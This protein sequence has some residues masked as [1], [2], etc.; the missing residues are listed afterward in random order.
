MFGNKNFILYF[1]LFKINF[2]KRSAGCTIYEIF[3]F[4]KAFENPCSFENPVASIDEYKEI[5]DAVLFG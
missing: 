1:I 4:K 5:S 2:F 3:R